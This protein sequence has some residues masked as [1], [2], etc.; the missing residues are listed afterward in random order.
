MRSTSR[1]VA[2]TAC[3][4][5]ESRSAISRKYGSRRW[6][7]APDPSRERDRQREDHHQE[8]NKAECVGVFG[9]P[10]LNWRR[11]LHH[12]TGYRRGLGELGGIGGKHPVD[13]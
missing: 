12:R 2:S 4:I 6:A 9:K 11:E 10:L 1:D 13:R 8:E 7:P 5:R 3:S